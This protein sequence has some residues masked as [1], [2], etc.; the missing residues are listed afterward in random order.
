[1]FV[2]GGISGVYSAVVPFDYHVHDTY[3][4]V[5]HIHYVL[6]GGCVF[7]VFAGVYYWFPKITG[8][9]YSETLGSWHF[10]LMFIGFN[11]TFFPMHWHRRWRA[12][13]AA[14]PTT[15]PKFERL[16]H[17]D[18]DLRVR[19]RRR[20]ADLRLQHDPLAGARRA[21][22]R[23]N[24]WRAL[25]IEWQVSSP[26]PSSTSTRTPRVVGGPYSYGEPG[27]RH[28][29]FPRSRTRRRAGARD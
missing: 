14:S 21:R 4:V 23:R 20:D 2:I 22:R 5:A 3:F 19:P 27:A 7:A 9:L 24:P 28:A 17:V 12:C 18:H 25:T 16:E 15:T 26:P 6:F 29:I 11:L 10:W 13:R 1:M 8:R